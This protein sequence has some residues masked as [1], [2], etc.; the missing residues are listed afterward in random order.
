MTPPLVLTTVAI[1]PGLAVQGRAARANAAHAVAAG[2]Q[3]VRR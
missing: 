1:V 2:R 3:D